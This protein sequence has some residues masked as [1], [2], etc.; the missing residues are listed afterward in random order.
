MGRKVFNIKNVEFLQ[1][2]PVKLLTKYSH[3]STNSPREQWKQNAQTPRFAHFLYYPSFPR[4]WT[5][6]VIVEFDF[7]FTLLSYTTGFIIEIRLEIFELTSSRTDRRT[8]LSLEYNSI[9]VNDLRRL[10]RRVTNFG[11]NLSLPP[12]SQRRHMPRIQKGTQNTRKLTKISS[13]MLLRG[14]PVPVSVCIN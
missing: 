13:C 4:N 12:V 14:R 8:S 10:L 9:H 11:V 7:K 6:C 2:F 5:N 3:Y 1:N